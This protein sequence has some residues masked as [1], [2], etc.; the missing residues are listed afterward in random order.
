MTDIG[1][2]TV[3]QQMRLLANEAKTKPTQSA[4]SQDQVSFAELLKHSV[5]RVNGIQQQAQQL[6]EAFERG[7]PQV[8]LAEV[9]IAGQKASIAFQ[10]VTQVRNHVLSA[11]KDI[12]SMQV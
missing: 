12:M 6:R 10:A 11:Y 8:S 4:D 5:D 7:E 9:M 2:N 1:I 3:M